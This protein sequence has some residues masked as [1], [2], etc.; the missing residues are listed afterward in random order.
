MIKKSVIFVLMMGL[1]AASNLAYSQAVSDTFSRAIGYTAPAGWEQTYKSF[2]G[3]M[4]YVGMWSPSANAYGPT[5]FCGLGSYGST[6]SDTNAAVCAQFPPILETNRSYTLITYTQ[7][8]IGLNLACNII[9]I[10]I[11]VWMDVSRGGPECPYFAVN[12]QYKYNPLGMPGGLWWPQDYLNRGKPPIKIYFKNGAEIRGYDTLWKRGEQRVDVSEGSGW[13]KVFDGFWDPDWPN[14]GGQLS[15]NGVSDTATL[16]LNL[17][18]SF[19]YTGGHLSVVF[20]NGVGLENIP[21][22]NIQ[23]ADWAPY[24]IYKFKCFLSVANPVSDHTMPYFG[25]LISYL[26]NLYVGYSWLDQNPCAGTNIML[27]RIWV[28]NWSG[29]GSQVGGG[30]PDITKYTAYVPFS[31]LNENNAGQVHGYGPCGFNASVRPN[32]HIV[33]KMQT[34][35]EPAYTLS[36]EGTGMITRYVIPNININMDGIGFRLRLKS[37]KFNINGTRPGIYPVARLYYSPTGLYTDTLFLG[38][39]QTTGGD[40]EIILETP[41]MVE[42]GNNNFIITYDIPEPTFE[43]G[44]SCDDPLVFNFISYTLGNRENGN[45]LGDFTDKEVFVNESFIKPVR[46]NEAILVLGGAEGQFTNKQ[47]CLEETGSTMSIPIIGTK[48]GGYLRGTY[49]GFSWDRSTDGGETWELGVSTDS[50]YTFETNTTY[51]SY[52]GTLVAPEGCQNN[53]SFVYNVVWETQNTDIAI[54]YTGNLT[55]TD[56][57]KV[58]QGQVLSFTSTA[59][60]GEHSIPSYNWEYS[61]DGGETWGEILGEV[62]ETLY[63]IV[64]RGL[65]GNVAIR[66]RLEAEKPTCQCLNVI[67]SNIFNFYAVGGEVDFIFVYQPPTSLYL[68]NNSKLDL[69]VSYAGRIDLNRSCWQKDGEDLSYKDRYLTINGL[70]LKD[71]GVYR[72]KAVDTIV[73]LVDGELVTITDNINY[74]SV[75]NV[76][77][78]QPLEIHYVSNTQNYALAGQNVGFKVYSS[79]ES[80]NGEQFNP[81]SPIGFQW[82]RHTSSGSDVQLDDD[83]YF[84][85]TKSNALVIVDIPD[86]NDPMYENIYT[87]NDAYYYLEIT[88]PCGSVDTRKTP[89]FLTPGEGI[90]FIKNNTNFVICN[91]EK[92]NFTATFEVEVK[93]PDIDLVKYQ[94]YIDGV[95]AEDGTNVIGSKTPTLTLYTSNLAV[96]TYCKVSAFVNYYF[97]DIDS[98]ETEIELADMSLFLVMS[99]VG[100]L[101]SKEIQSFID[102]SSGISMDI[103][104]ETNKPASSFVFDINANNGM[105]TTSIYSETFPAGNFTT[106]NISF[107]HQIIGSKLQDLLDLLDNTDATLTATITNECG[108]VVKVDWDIINEADEEEGPVVSNIKEKVV[109]GLSLTP[110]PTNGIINLAYNSNI[111]TSVSIELCNLNGNCILTLYDGLTYVGENKLEFN[112][113]NHN[114]AAGTYTLKIST[115]NGS[116]TKQFVFV[117]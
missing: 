9:R 72:Y 86:K 59:E 75:C 91:N 14:F 78:V 84:K 53:A 61:L 102:N 94:W 4:A 43:N 73:K 97:V 103:I 24:W 74:S 47:F 85:G 13:V 37:V 3:N 39:V 38:S 89:I 26:D 115:K 10:R 46:F 88:G 5:S 65:R 27:P 82:Y 36:S 93:T 6:A 105:T 63:Y 69:A 21:P 29:G 77:I 44:L 62:S 48:M 92:D 116:I 112:L 95:A 22:S 58:E 16:V 67:Y 11:P 18:T 109:S 70:T 100:N 28:V 76:N 52:R 79:F 19:P 55:P 34:L 99:P 15:W 23:S 87:F 33:G 7:E 83:Y 35:G 98:D 20:E 31:T 12:S 64:P 114:I 49:L 117:K 66:L 30:T 90:E 101:T 104:I 25:P 110:N 107:T 8:E 111:E 60:L 1:F 108:D 42:D 45:V 56:L 57:E 113:T 17:V 2:K 81:A 54:Q 50:V 51:N 71:G 41:R 80:G 40:D 96:K 106:P 68:C 32:M